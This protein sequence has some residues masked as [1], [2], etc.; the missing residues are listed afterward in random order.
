MQQASYDAITLNLDPG[1]EEIPYPPDIDVR[2]WVRLSDVMAERGLG[3]NGAQVAS[4]DMVALHAREIA[5]RVRGYDTDYVLVDCP[6]QIELFTFRQSSKVILEALGP[7]ESFILYLSDP[8]LTR[9]PSG[10]IAS[11]LLSSTTQF[12]LRMPFFN[13]LSKADLLTEEE[14]ERIVEW[15]GDP[16]ILYDALVAELLE[17]EN[18]LNLEFLRAMEAIGVYKRLTPVSSELVR[19]LEDVYDAVQQAFAGGEDLEKR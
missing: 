6:G 12:R 2:D 16:Q 17:P 14:V 19:G 5:Q 9:R 13:I 4:A 18:I 1:A 8:L 15:S 3:P 7:E 10:L 11:M